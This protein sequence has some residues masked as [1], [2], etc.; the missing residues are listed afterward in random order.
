MA[1]TATHEHT[2]EAGDDNEV[3]SSVLG[4]MGLDPVSLDDDGLD[5]AV[6][7]CGQLRGMV[8]T[9]EARFAE[10]IRRRRGA[11]A[12]EETLRKRQR[13]S[14]KKAKRRAKTAH[15]TANKIRLVPRLVETVQNLECVLADV[16][17]RNNMF[18]ARQYAH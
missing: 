2:G 3:V 11:Y 13:M 5:L 6:E 17:A 15:A 9:A 7:L 1:A 16:R 10:E 8:S 12:A 14:A 18:V 4:V